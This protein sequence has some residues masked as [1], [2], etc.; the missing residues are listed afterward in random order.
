[1]D[2]STLESANV[3]W[4]TFISGKWFEKDGRRFVHGTEGF[5][6]R[7]EVRA[8]GQID[9]RALKAK[10]IHRFESRIDWSL[11]DMAEPSLTA[12]VVGEGM[13]LINGVWQKCCWWSLD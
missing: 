11:L 5:R 8:D 4:P 1:M 13:R 10:L 3:L 2:E 6:G 9:N 7:I 12:V